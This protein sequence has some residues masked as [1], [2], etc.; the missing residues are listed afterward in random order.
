MHGMTQQLLFS[1]FSKIVGSAG[2]WSTRK[3]TLLYFTWYLI[4]FTLG[5]CIKNV[6]QCAECLDYR[7]CQRCQEG[8]LLLESYW[9]PLCVSS[10]PD[11]FTTVQ[12]EENGLVCKNSNGMY[13]K[14]LHVQ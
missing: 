12:I 9:G 4:A 3:I 7:A 5:S 1:R 2:R 8:Y 14:E 6:P 11:G 10:C 13:K